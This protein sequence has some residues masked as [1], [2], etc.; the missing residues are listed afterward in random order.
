M[1]QFVLCYLYEVLSE[2]KGDIIFMK[3][4][5][6]KILWKLFLSM[7]YLSTFTF[8]GGY[9]IVTLMKDTFVDKYQWIS[10]KEMLNYVAIAQSAPGAIAVNGAIVVGYQLAGFVGIL[11]AVLGTV[12][13]PFIIISI[14]SLFYAA[15]RE[16]T[17]ISLLLE[18]MQAGVGAVVAVVTFDLAVGVIREKKLVLNLMMVVA[19]FANVL[20]NVSVIIIMIASILTG[21]LFNFISARKETNE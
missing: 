7:L 16:N 5:E 17:I 11:V 14:I 20:F 18:G 21:V 4:K 9:V 10:E 15:F 3:E 8:G 13:P 19:F 1:Q 2:F 6:D 12:I